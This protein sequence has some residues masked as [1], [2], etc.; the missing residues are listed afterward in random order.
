M[1]YYILI[2]FF[3]IS[4]AG[5]QPLKPNENGDV[6]IRIQENLPLDVCVPK[7]LNEDKSS[8]WIKYNNQKV[9]PEKAFL[10]FY[11]CIDLLNPAKFE[12]SAEQ[13]FKQSHEFNLYLNSD[14]R[15]WIS[16]HEFLCE[17]TPLCKEN[18]VIYKKFLEENI[19]E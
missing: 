17:E 2:I 15:N 13:F 6:A 3:L 1:K 4:C 10:F 5:V 11:A 18:K 16:T 14:I 7:C 9:C 19:Y 12:L 8:A